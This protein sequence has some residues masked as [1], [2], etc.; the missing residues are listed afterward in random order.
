MGDIDGGTTS[1]MLSQLLWWLAERR[2]RVLVIMT[3]NNARKLPPELHRDGRID[4]TMWFGG[5]EAGP[6]A[7]QFVSRVLKTFPK[8]KATDADAKAIAQSCFKP[9]PETKKSPWMVAQATL[10]SAAYAWVKNHG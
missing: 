8:V 2:S 10:T 9:D 1:T 5:L 4:T 3:T 6:P 7:E